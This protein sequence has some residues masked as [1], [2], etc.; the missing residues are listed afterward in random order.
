MLHLNGRCLG[1]QKKN[2][3]AARPGLIAP[4][5]FIVPVEPATPASD[6]A[7][8]HVSWAIE[9]GQSFF[10]IG[11]SVGSPWAT[12]TLTQAVSEVANAWRLLGIAHPHRGEGRP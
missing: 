2:L 6:I 3:L 1:P 11:R 7:I 4:K 8:E 12:Y 10:D 9:H 5:I